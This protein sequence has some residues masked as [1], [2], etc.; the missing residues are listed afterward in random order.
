MLQIIYYST[1]V[2]DFDLSDGIESLLIWDEDQ[3]MFLELRLFLF[4][5]P[6][7]FTRTGLT[8]M[9]TILPSFLL[10]SAV[11]WTLPSPAIFAGVFAGID[12]DGTGPNILLTM[13]ELL[14]VSLTL[15]TEADGVAFASVD[16][17]VLEDDMNVSRN[18]QLN[19]ARNWHFFTERPAELAPVW[20]AYNIEVEPPSAR[21]FTYL[22]IRGSLGHRSQVRELGEA[23]GDA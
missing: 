23:Y 10:F 21:I 17:N 7:S 16:S 13:A 12:I 3:S 22:S 4:S 6:I 20:N 19:D 8:A 9:G 15:A 14:P 11:C 1:V 2:D 18:W 5:R